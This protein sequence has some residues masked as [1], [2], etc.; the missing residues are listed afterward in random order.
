MFKWQSKQIQ[1]YS[2]LSFPP[3]L[4]RSSAP[5][6]KVNKHSWQLKHSRK[7]TKHQKA[8]TTFLLKDYSLKKTSNM[9]TLSTSNDKSIPT[10]PFKNTPKFIY[11]LQLMGNECL[12]HSLSGIL[13][14]I[15]LNP[16]NNAL[17]YLISP[18]YRWRK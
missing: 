6:N 10:L 18:F 1:Y 7:S 17:N 8:A 14:F 16:C 12:F 13:H 4:L 2:S 15:S 5:S 11:N 3:I 9:S